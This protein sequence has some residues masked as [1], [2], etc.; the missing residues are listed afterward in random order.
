MAKK[1][2]KKKKKKKKVKHHNLFCV[3]LPTKNQQCA[4]EITLRRWRSG[5]KTRP[6]R[7]GKLKKLIWLRSSPLFGAL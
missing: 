2:K 1:E 3:P 5:Q 7:G 4:Q 6:M